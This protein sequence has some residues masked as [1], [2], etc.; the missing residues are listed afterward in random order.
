MGVICVRI[1]RK[2]QEN[3]VFQTADYIENG[4]GCWID[5]TEKTEKDG[6]IMA[7]EESKYAKVGKNR[8]KV[9]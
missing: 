6:L 7:A 4:L 9:L 8:L 3:T 1:Q 5:V 2:E